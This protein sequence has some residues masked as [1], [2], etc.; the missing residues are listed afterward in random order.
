MKN[1]WDGEIQ[2]SHGTSHAKGVMILF[3]N[4]LDIQIKHTSTDDNG[5][6]IFVDM[7][8][9]RYPLQL[10]NIYAPTKDCDQIRFFHEVNTLFLKHDTPSA[11]VILTTLEIQNWIEKAVL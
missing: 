6:Y 10:M 1:Q 5:R 4:G 9:E 3:K 7:M 8:L 2:L 11:K